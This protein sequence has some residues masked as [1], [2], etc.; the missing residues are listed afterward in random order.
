MKVAN[1]PY[2][3]IIGLLVVI[4][5]LRECRKVDNFTPPSA[6]TVYVYVDSI[7][8]V[9]V[10]HHYPVPTPYQVIDSFFIPA[11]VDTALIL[12]DW[13]LKR[14][15]ELVIVD[16][17]TGKL[18]L[19]TSVQK[20]R[21]GEYELQGALHRLWRT[22]IKTETITLQ[23]RNK[24][25]AGFI[26]GYNG[27]DMGVAPTIYFLSK[28]THLYSISYDPFNKVEIGRAHV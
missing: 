2:I 24:L 11:K 18:T 21:L 15:Y 10:Y 20:N 22:K 19:K 17:S 26:L 1:I 7:V 25:L 16:D 4:F 5:F 28:K 6:D 14:N 3:I 12:A 8:L 27:R 9:P 23:E 13:F